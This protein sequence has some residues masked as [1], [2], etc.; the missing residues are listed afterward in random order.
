[1]RSVLKLSPC[2]S[3]VYT[4]TVSI[5]LQW[6]VA[7]CIHTILVYCC[8]KQA[9]HVH[10]SI[11]FDTNVSQLLGH[12][13]PW[14]YDPLPSLGELSSSS[15]NRLS[16]C[17]SCLFWLCIP[18]VVYGRHILCLRCLR[19]AFFSEKKRGFFIFFPKKMAWRQPL[20]RPDVRRQTSAL[21]HLTVWRQ[22]RQQST[23]VFSRKIL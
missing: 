11:Q 13:I 4:D 10:L 2:I 20:V 6:H 5:G 17:L 12:V 7:W 8:N 19:V 9:S 18:P 22:A 21:P 3:I 1:M 14:S 15:L 16:V 23:G